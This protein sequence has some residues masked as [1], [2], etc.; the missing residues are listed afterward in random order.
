MP[1]P[2]RADVLDPCR[3]EDPPEM[4]TRQ[5]LDRLSELGARS[6]YVLRLFRKHQIEI[7]IDVP[8]FHFQFCLRPLVF[9]QCRQCACPNLD[10]PFL[11]GLRWLE[12]RLLEGTRC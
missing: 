4:S 2:M 3:L 12:C 10:G 11:T 6:L 8:V 7:L 1:H 9:A 5:G